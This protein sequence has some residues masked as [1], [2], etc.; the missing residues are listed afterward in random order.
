MVKQ[1]VINFAILLIS[2]FLIFGCAS[3][4]YQRVTDD[5]GKIVDKI[6][7]ELDEHKLSKQLSHDKIN[8][9]KNDIKID[10]DNYVF[11]LKRAKYELIK[12]NVD[13]KLDFEEGIIIESTGWVREFDNKSKIICQITYLNSTYLEKINGSDNAEEGE[14]KNDSATIV[15]NLFISKYMM[16]SDNVF[17]GME[18]MSGVDGKNYFDYYSS[19]YGEFGV[20][21]IQL[22][23]IYGTT[24]SRLKSNADY[25][26]Q[27]DGINYHL[28]EIGTQNEEYKTIQLSYYYRTAVGAGWYILALALSIAL[29]IF[30]I[31][32]YIVK[33][34][35]NKYKAKIK[36]ENFI[37][38][39]EED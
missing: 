22:S 37:N 28:W 39:K 3:I 30:L 13:T 35:P 32:Y 19:N 1:R 26:Q 17:S 15:K 18:D 33:I 14:V 27:I 4:E 25:T 24:D 7:I 31:L 9:L 20:D 23:Q 36:I 16:Y 21:D 2:I 8:A 10:I 11:A 34:K 12:N 6:V 38:D 29:A 5:Y